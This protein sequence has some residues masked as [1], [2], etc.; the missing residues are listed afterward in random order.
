MLENDLK[1]YSCS[2][3]SN[4]KWR[5]LFSV[6]ND[7]N[8]PLPSCVWKLVTDKDP[9]KGFIPDIEQL[10]DSYVGDCGALNGPFSFNTIEW[11]FLPSKVGHRHYEK[12][13]V[14]YSYQNIEAIKN[15]IDSVGYFE[16]EITDEGIKIYGYKP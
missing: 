4:A 9:Q 3:M 6:I 10:G 12:A 16:Y 11:L 15:L 14:K 8:I 5:K 7:R 1:K 2:F 13:P